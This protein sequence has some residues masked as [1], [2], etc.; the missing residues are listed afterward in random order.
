M[1]TTDQPTAILTAPREG[2]LSTIEISKK[3]DAM[4]PAQ[5]VC[6]LRASGVQIKTARSR[7]TTDCGRST[8]MARYV[9]I[10]EDAA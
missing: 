2:S 3:L 6:E 8:R 7:E 4:N 10:R 5:R 1:S 9:L